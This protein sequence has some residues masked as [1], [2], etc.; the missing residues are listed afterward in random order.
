MRTAEERF[1]NLKEFRIIPPA[2]DPTRAPL[3]KLQLSEEQRQRYENL[4]FNIL[5]LN[6]KGLIQ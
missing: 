6:L 1:S 5:N 3:Q 4:F 2:Q